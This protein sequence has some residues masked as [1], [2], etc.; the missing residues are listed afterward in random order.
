[1]AGSASSNSW[2][3]GS[4]SQ[5]TWALGWLRLIAAANGEANTTSPMAEVR[6]MR[7]RF[8]VDSI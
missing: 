1:M 8:M 5:A 6:T 4:T 7:T 2:M 3:P